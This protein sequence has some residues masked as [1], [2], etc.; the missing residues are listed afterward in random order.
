VQEIVSRAGWASGNAIA[1]MIRGDGLEQN[2]RIADSYD[3]SAAQAPLLIVQY[4]ETNETPVL[5]PIGDRSA[6]E[7]AQMTI[8]VSATDPD[9]IPVL[10]VDMSDLPGGHDGALAGGLFTWTP[11][12]GDAAGGPYE[13][14][15][16]ATDEADA[17]LTDSETISVT[18][19]ASPPANATPVLA[20][21]GARSAVEGTTLSVGV[22]ATDDS[23]DP[24]LSADLS[25]LPVGGDQ[26]FSDLGGGVGTLTWQPVAGDAPGPYA[27]TIIA[28]DIVDNTL[29]DQET[30]NISVTAEL[31]EAGGEVRDLTLELGR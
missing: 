16:T 24:I 25:N 29:T 11:Q 7:A 17:T 9:G 10:S 5:A 2:S 30:F 21:I 13:L 6:D 3:G 14:I 1:L 31:Q 19:V 26:I 18:V 15:F 8:A 23:G 27:V 28:T 4:G 12:V 20:G 22:T